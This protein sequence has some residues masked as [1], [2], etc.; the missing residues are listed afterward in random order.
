MNDRSSLRL[1]AK[2]AY[3]EQI[4]GVPKKTRIA[5]SVFYKKERAVALAK[6]LH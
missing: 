5:F 4:K 6:L 1:K 3:K 2:K